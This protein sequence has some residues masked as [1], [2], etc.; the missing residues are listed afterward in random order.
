MTLM[1]GDPVAEV[2]KMPKNRPMKALTERDLLRL[3][4]KIGATVFGPLKKGQHREFFC[5]DAKT[6]IWYEEWTDEQGKK[7]QTTTRYEIHDKGI[8]KVQEGARYSYIK[9]EELKN[10]TLA[11]QIY[12]EKVAR[13][14][15]KR[16]PKTG[17]TLA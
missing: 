16:D 4:S 11:T 7:Q 9:G 1:T 8:L 17:E 13:E 6:W 10:L 12:Y 3:E 14:I 2:F 15:Y 5:F